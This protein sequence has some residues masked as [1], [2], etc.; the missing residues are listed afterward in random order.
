M[1]AG[2]ADGGG[3][4]DGPL[5]TAGGP[6]YCGGS[7]TGG[8]GAVRGAMGGSFGALPVVGG[9]PGDLGPGGGGAAT[10]FYFRAPS[11]SM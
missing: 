2:G 7:D 10:D 6:P 3:A 9:G 11:S 8:D 4:I 5:G 1:F